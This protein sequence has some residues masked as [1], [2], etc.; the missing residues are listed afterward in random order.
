MHVV[1][2][3]SDIIGVTDYLCKLKLRSLGD[4]VKKKSQSITLEKFILGEGGARKNAIQICLAILL[5]G[6]VFMWAD[7]TLSTIF[8]L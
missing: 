2:K 5:Y 7:K 1:S 4:V 8:P 3:D 6:Q